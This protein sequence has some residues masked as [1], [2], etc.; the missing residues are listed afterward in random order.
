MLSPWQTLAQ[1]PKYQHRTAL[2]NSQ[3][4][5]F[6]WQDLAKK[7]QSVASEL[8]AQGVRKNSGVA[9]WGGNDETLLLLYLS[10]LQIGARV[11]VL[12]PAFSPEKIQAILAKNHMAFLYLGKDKVEMEKYLSKIGA[13]VLLTTPNLGTPTNPISTISALHIAL[14][15]T[16]TSGSTGLPKAVVHNVQ[17]HL[18]NAQ[19]VCELMHFT[20]KDSYLLSLPLYHVSGQGIVWRWLYQGGELHLPRTDFYSSVCSASHCSLVPTQAQRFLDYLDKHPHLPRHTAHIL[21]GGASIPVSLTQSLEKKGIQSY[22]SYGMTEM[23]STIFAK[24]AD[25]SAGVGQILP[26]REYQIICG[27]IYIKGAGLALG[28]WQEN[29]II[30][31]TNEIGFFATKDKGVWRDGE[32]FITGRT[33]NQFISGGENIQPEEIEDIIKMHPQ[34]Q[35]VFVLPLPDPEFGQR[36]VAMVAFH[37]PFSRDLVQDLQKFLFAKL[38]KFKHPTAY[39]PLEWGTE[40][41]G[42][43]VSRHILQ[44]KLHQLIEP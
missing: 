1:H 41:G 9:L 4:V 25:H 29:T 23:A 37:V 2:R 12:N 21:M 27:E 38:E 3:G 8:L 39:Y 31:F 36:P 44:E 6:S 17:A 24:K 10:V 20:S 22:C 26:H 34:V 30:P 40:Q 14:T 33:D 35:Q 43:K 32:L 7:I 5:T 18:D 42:I 13:W 28:Y 11:M 19:G 15:M 16:L